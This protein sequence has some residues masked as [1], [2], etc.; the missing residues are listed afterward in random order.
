MKSELAFFF[1]IIKYL[2]KIIINKM[3][4]AVILAVNSNGLLEWTPLNP[5]SEII[6]YE[7]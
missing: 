5:S 4:M 7:A 1:G 2:H 6:S 3:L